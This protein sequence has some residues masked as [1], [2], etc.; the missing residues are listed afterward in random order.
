[1]AQTLKNIPR[2]HLIPGPEWVLIQQHDTTHTEAGVILPDTAKIVVQ[3]AIKVGKDVENV[4]E[5]DIVILR[6]SSSVVFVP[7]VKGPCALVPEGAIVG[8]IRGYDWRAQAM[9]D[10]RLANLAS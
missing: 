2:K 4:R 8:V 1:M 10:I 5:G 9:A 3:V 7:E 6:D